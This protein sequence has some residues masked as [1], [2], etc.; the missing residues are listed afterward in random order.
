[1]QEKSV[2]ILI[3]DDDLRMRE[4]LRE[5]LAFYDLHSTLA[6][7]GQQALEFL[8]NKPFDLVLLDIDMPKKN[9]FQ[10]MSEINLHY[11][12]TDIIVLSGKASFEN[13]RQAFS[14]GAKDFLNKPYDPSELIEL[15]HKIL[16][17]RH[18]NTQKTNKKL[19]NSALSGVEKTLVELESIIHN[20]DLT[21]ASEI[22]NSS[23][24]VAFLWKNLS[25]WP[26]QFVSENV[27]D[28]S[29]YTA[30][31]FI[32][33]K[34]I[35]RDIIHPDDMERVIKETIQDQKNIKLK[36]KL[37]RIITKFGVVK[38]V[39]DNS[40][41]V[42]DEQGN[43]THYQ[44]IIIDVTERELARQKMMQN[45]MSLEHVA[46]H[47]ALTG[48][49]NRLLLLDRMQQSIKKAQRA[50][51][52]LCV[53]YID[54]DK[55][56]PIND[57]LGHAAGDEVLKVT[58]NRFSKNIRAVDTVARIGGDEF[59]VLMESVSDVQDVKAMAQKLN[60]SLNRSILW[61]RHELF[62][63]S[64]IGISLSPD[65]GDNAEELMKK[66]DNAMY[67]SKVKGGNSYQLYQ[68]P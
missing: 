31:E 16:Q 7:N 23:P 8:K 3:V 63:T 36:H 68:Q 14:L 64:S 53:L 58:A 9:G 62:I 67:Q 18:L 49:P 26:I 4:S 47:D 1:M 32:A 5:L 20:E 34:V 61:E 56:K 50:K 15:I 19:D 45:Q 43:I 54:L 39:E 52:Y 41:M 59:I 24:V 44:G 40:S 65:D 27:V 28:L 10:V 13:A 11:S 17:K 55:F 42:R 6:E 2:A 35:Y 66:A 22:I 51:K 29:G 57:T 37:Y 38:W 48:L 12:A 25:Y 30:N 33:Q 60:Q 46:Y 21:F